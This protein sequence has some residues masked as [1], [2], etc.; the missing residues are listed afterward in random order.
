MEFDYELTKEDRKLFIKESKKIKLFDK[1]QKIG[2][3]NIILGSLMIYLNLPK[4][5]NLYFIGRFNVFFHPICDIILILILFMIIKRLL[6]AGICLYRWNTKGRISLTYENINIYEKKRF[7]SFN[8]LQIRKVFETENFY[9]IQAAGNGSLGG[10]L[11]V[12]PKRLL[13]SEDEN[14]HIKELMDNY[15]NKLKCQSPKFII[16]EF[17]FF[18][19]IIF[20]FYIAYV[21]VLVSVNKDVFYNY[22][23]DLSIGVEL[24]PQLCIFKNSPFNDKNETFCE[25]VDKIDGK[26]VYGKSPKQIID[27]I[28]NG[29]RNTTVEAWEY[30]PNTTKHILKKSNKK[31]VTVY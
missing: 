20:L 8:S 16:S 13:K 9:S 12:I 21:L 30:Y 29:K 14:N 2:V 3:F 1:F 24:M 4:E 25:Q 22:D 17:I 31:G 26:E 10:F 19:D 6:P 11:I 23:K 27:M 7:F 18:L 28:K 5:L 15:A